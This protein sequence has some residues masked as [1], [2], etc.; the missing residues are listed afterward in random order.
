MVIA[1]LCTFGFSYVRV[2]LVEGETADYINT[3]LIHI[4]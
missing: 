3:L 4:L 2:L 1:A